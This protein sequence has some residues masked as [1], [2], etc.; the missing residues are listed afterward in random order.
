M[1]RPTDRVDVGWGLPIGEPAWQNGQIRPLSVPSLPA[2]VVRDRKRVVVLQDL[3][4]VAGRRNM[5][6][7]NANAAMLS[8]HPHVDIYSL[9][10]LSGLASTFLIHTRPTR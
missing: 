3:E 7:A 9:Y 6:S 10:T 1:V 8:A 4:A 2:L 5:E